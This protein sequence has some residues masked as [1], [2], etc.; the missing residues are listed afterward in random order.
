MQVGI[1][2]YSKNSMVEIRLR[3]LVIM[4][5]IILTIAI[6]NAQFVKF[7]ATLPNIQQ[8][9]NPNVFGYQKYN[10]IQYYSIGSYTFISA[11]PFFCTK[12]SHGAVHTYHKKRNKNKNYIHFKLYFIMSS[13][14]RFP[15]RESLRGP[16]IV[17]GLGTTDITYSNPNFKFNDYL[18]LCLK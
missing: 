14:P 6:E 2:E 1:I 17:H 12:F 7:H 3:T 16:P 13:R 9:E 11:E 8:S 18:L 15:L 5:D 4:I 10:I